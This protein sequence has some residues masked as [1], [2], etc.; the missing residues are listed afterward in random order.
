M[1]LMLAACVAVLGLTLSSP[2][3]A[4]KMY[5]VTINGALPELLD[6]QEIASLPPYKRIT[7]LE[8]LR[9]ALVEME[10]M[11]SG[12]SAESSQFKDAI[13]ALLQQFTF[14]DQAHAEAAPGLPY[15]QNGKW[16]CGAGYR[17]DPRVGTCI[18]QSAT[19]R[20]SFE[21]GGC[22]SNREV[23]SPYNA[24]FQNS[25]VCVPQ[26]AWNDLPERRQ[27][28]LGWAGKNYNPRGGVYP[29]QA[30]HSDSALANPEQSRSLVTRRQTDSPPI[31]P[32][33]QAE[34]PPPVPQGGNTRPAVTHW[35]DSPALPEADADRRHQE[36]G[37]VIGCRGLLKPGESYSQEAHRQALQGFRR[38]G[39]NAST[40]CLM[41]GSF[42]EYQGSTVQKGKCKVV[43][44]FPAGSNPENQLKCKNP[45][46]SMCN[47]LLFCTKPQAPTTSPVAAR[48]AAPPARSA[49]AT[50]ALAVT[51]AAR[52][53]P[54]PS[55][56][57]A[58]AREPICLNVSTGLTEACSK[59]MPAGEKCDPLDA[60]HKLPGAAE[61]WRKF[62]EN[63][64]ALCKPD[65]GFV[66][67]F[68]K[69]CQV[70][71]ARIRGLNTDSQITRGSGAA[72]AGSTNPPPATNR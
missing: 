47:P 7:Y 49:G 68:C 50:R 43:G 57:A 20:F 24:G 30:F 46:Q 5:E 8:G 53:E 13:V 15:V 29:N 69:E 36:S 54:A 52:T 45:K 60:K 51:P 1:N 26:Q 11:G 39:T 32:S 23:F 6:Y 64:D 9:K 14:I 65:N 22:G 59:A 48:P 44:S 67:F 16:A 35:G 56:P 33:A 19:G 72:P 70:L 55:S 27:Q 58:D 10:K 12:K 63:F 31:V 41:G 40:A 18:V 21:R 37:D 4:K 61:E 34:P 62:K 42:S 66:K 25:V 2:A 38:E 3:A 28:Q 71:S 17:F